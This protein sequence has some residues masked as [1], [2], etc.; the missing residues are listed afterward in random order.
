MNA[1]AV[2]QEH[3]VVGRRTPM[4][5][6]GC[7]IECFAPDAEFGHCHEI[8]VAAPSGLVFDVAESFDLSSIKAVYAI[9]WLRARLLGAPPPARDALKGLVSRAKSMGWGELARRPGRELVM[10]AAVQPWLR[11]PVFEALSPE[12]FLSYSEPE[13]VKIVWTLEAEPLDPDSTIFRTETRVD[14][15]DEA[16]R[17]R[18]RRYWRFAGVGIVLVRLLALPHIRREAER[19]ARG[20]AV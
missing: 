4:R 10:G 6:D 20:R 7:L 2:P 11:E 15:T 5:I 19:R 1:S 12:R 17:L 14:P 18:F 3:D 16:A 8:R 9:F 13:Q